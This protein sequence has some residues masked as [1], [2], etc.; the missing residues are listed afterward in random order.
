MGFDLLPQWNNTLKD[1]DKYF[2]GF[3]DQFNRLAKMHDDMVKNIANYPPYN[4]RKTGDNTYRIELAVAG[5]SKSDIDITM[6]DDKLVVKGFIRDDYDNQ[7]PEDYVFKGIANRAFTRMFALSDQVEVH[8]AELVNGMLRIFLERIIP[9][10][11][12][13]KK[14]EISDEPSTVSLFAKNNPQLLQEQDLDQV[15]V[16]TAAKRKTA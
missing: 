15:E 7:A 5:F 9:E 10:H 6:E 13:P 11:K 8:N 16:K 2:V 4:I 14:I 12:K 1:F 3:D